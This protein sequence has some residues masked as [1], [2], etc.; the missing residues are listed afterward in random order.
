MASC[1]T[2]DPSSLAYGKREI[3]IDNAFVLPADRSVVGI[4]QERASNAITQT[5]ALNTNSAL[6]GENFFRVTFYG[7]V[8][9]AGASEHTLSYTAL[10]DGRISRELRTE[11]AGVAMSRSPYYVQNNY[12]PFSYATGTAPNG[13]GC[14]YAW[15]QIRSPAHTQNFFQNRGRIDLRLRL[16][17]TGATQEK[18]LASMYEFTINS[19]IAASGWNPY[20]EPAGPSPELGRPGNPLLAPSVNSSL[21][22]PFPA[23]DLN[24][25]RLNN[26]LLNPENTRRSD[27]NTSAPKRTLSNQMQLAP[28]YFA[29]VAQPYS[30]D[31]Y[32]QVP[33]TVPAP[34]QVNMIAPHPV[35]ILPNSPMQPQLQVPSPA[36]SSTLPTASAPRTVPSPG[37]VINAPAITVPSPCKLATHQSSGATAGN[38]S[39][40]CP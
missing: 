25:D 40:V 6:S 15:Q 12:G 31:T 9:S 5:I 36:V 27:G 39:I 13:D 33:I 4:T 19:T 16:C 29:P 10:T 11:M 14:I 37:Q 18:L 2:K 38:S 28:E 3:G 22:G 21:S 1:A 17:E 7:P 35:A 32:P 23:S 26:T 34:Q 24:T 8:N 20:G 30:V